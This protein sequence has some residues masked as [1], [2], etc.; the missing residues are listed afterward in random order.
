MTDDQKRGRESFFKYA[1]ENQ[2]KII[3]EAEAII[4]KYQK[5]GR[6]GRY[7]CFK[8]LKNMPSLAVS[9]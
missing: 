4:E 8:L 3:K 2:R 1:I 7:Q 9:G 5:N 6:R